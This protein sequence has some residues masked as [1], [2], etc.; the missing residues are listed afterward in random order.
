MLTNIVSSEL[1]PSCMPHKRTANRPR[2]QEG[3]TYSLIDCVK[4]PLI[5]SHPRGPEQI[6]DVARW[7]QQRSAKPVRTRT[8][9]AAQSFQLR[10]P[11]AQ[12]RSDVVRRFAED[13]FLETVLVAV[14]LREHRTGTHPI[15]E[16]HRVDVV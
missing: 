14:R 13:V 9:Q 16:C 2:R 7:R 8:F 4:N 11:V 10:I 6:P 5:R 15:V 12:E 3:G 1:R